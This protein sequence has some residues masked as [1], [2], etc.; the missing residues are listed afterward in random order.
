MSKGVKN[1]YKNNKPITFLE[2]FTPLDIYTLAH[3][4]RHKIYVLFSIFS[5]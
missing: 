5:I 2:W 1:N 4:K 3:L